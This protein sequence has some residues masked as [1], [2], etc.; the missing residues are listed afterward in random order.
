VDIAADI[1][2]DA[3]ACT[4]VWAL[5]FIAGWSVPL[6]ALTLRFVVLRDRS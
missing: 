2:F 6:H 4:T 3:L 5:C 1:T